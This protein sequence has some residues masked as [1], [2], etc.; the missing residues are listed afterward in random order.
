MLTIRRDIVKE[1]VLAGLNQKLM[2][3][4]IMRTMAMLGVTDILSIGREHIMLPNE[5]P[6][7]GTG[8]G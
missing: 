4:E 1:T 5:L 3:P 2:Q 8:V 7:S 6:V